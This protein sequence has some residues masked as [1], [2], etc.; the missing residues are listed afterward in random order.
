ADFCDSD[1]SRP[2]FAQKG[3][4]YFPLR[5]IRKTI[6]N[7][8]G[9]KFQYQYYGLASSFRDVVLSASLDLGHFHPVHIILDGEYVRNVAWKRDDIASKFVTYY[10]NSIPLGAKVPCPQNDPNCTPIYDGGNQGWLARMTIG[11]RELKQ[12]GDWNAFVGYKW[13]ESDAVL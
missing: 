13:L 8:F 10:N 4:S 1:V 11:Y 3:N 5:D 2:S 12:F 6:D 7:D 9:N